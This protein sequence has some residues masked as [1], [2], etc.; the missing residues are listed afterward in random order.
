MP[1]DHPGN[2]PESRQS[3]I[4]LAGRRV[5]H[6]AAKVSRFPL[7]RLN[8]VREE[9][10][11]TLRTSLA[12]ILVTAAACGADLL[13]LEVARQLGVRRRVVLPTTPDIFKAT[14][15]V[16]R[17]GAWESLFDL[18]IA[19]VEADGDLL[20]CRQGNGGESTDYFQTNHDIL[21]E[22]AR[23]ASE[24]GMDLQVV[25]VWDGVSRGADDVTAHFLAEARRRSIPITEILTIP[26][27]A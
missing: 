24:S 2:R 27:S 10:R 12:G 11:R 25:V 23:L 9:I 18:L 7:A 19:E 20:I 4:A 16:D 26:H 5:D 13:A 14:S 6:P 22:A 15:V 17:P 21:D 3:V 8:E 1:P